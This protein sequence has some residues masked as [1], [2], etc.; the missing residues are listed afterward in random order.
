M[1]EVLNPQQFDDLRK[2]HLKGEQLTR[3]E[4]RA[5]IAFLRQDRTAAAA[6]AKAS[7][8]SKTVPID[9]NSLFQNVGNGNAS[10]T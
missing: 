2:R 1:T 10:Q 9:I 5:A 3:E 8:K 4:L 6:S 7:S